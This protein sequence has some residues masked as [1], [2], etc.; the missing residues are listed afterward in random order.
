MK[1][2]QAPAIREAIMTEFYIG[3]LS[4]TSMDAVDVALV[5]FSDKYPHL[6]VTH[7]EKF[8]AELKQQL[9]QLILEKNTSLE[10]F[11]KLDT[12]LGKLFAVAVNNLLA[13]SPIKKENIL[14]IGSH[15]QTIF[16]HPNDDAPF[17]LQIGDA[18]IIAALTGIKTIADFRNKDI[19]LGGQGAPLTPAFHNILFRNTE[20]NRAV[21]NIGGISNITYLPKDL[22]KPIIG[23]DP[24]PGNTLLDL[25]AEKHL[26]K[27]YDENG[28]WAASGKVDNILLNDLLADPYFHFPL[29]KSAGREHFNLAWLEAHLSPTIKAKDVQATL[30]ALTAKSITTHI[31]KYSPLTEEII[32][33]GGGVHNL[34][35]LETLQ[36]NLETIPLYS[37]EKYGV[38]PDWV[39]AMTFAWLAKQHLSQ[40]PGNLPSVTGAS[41]AAILGCVYPA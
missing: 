30:S 15:G 1:N 26:Q 14:A 34:H 40:L 24:G 27:S 8:P 36:A 20:I 13:I 4:G 28:Q 6:I 21:I 39:E 29:P 11:G 12:K 25:W 3:I 37:S 16:H 10:N 32:L 17:S 5:D 31:E 41:K 2:L 7:S 23:F 9:H 22:T 35:L 33:C 18:N 19:A 38:H